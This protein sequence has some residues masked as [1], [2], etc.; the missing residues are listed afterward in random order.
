MKQKIKNLIL[1]CIA[2]ILCVA[3]LP[4]APQVL[5]EEVQITPYAYRDSLLVSYEV[6]E[7]YNMGTEYRNRQ[8]RDFTYVNGYRRTDHN[9]GRMELSP[10]EYEFYA[11]AYRWT[12]TY[13]FY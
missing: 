4:L 12:V 7:S 6:W 8:Y 1:F 5:A 13:E 10:L 9:E 2:G 3:F 11:S